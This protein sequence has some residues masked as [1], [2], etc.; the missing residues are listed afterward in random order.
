M[1]ERVYLTAVVDRRSVFVALTLASGCASPPVEPVNAVPLTPTP[2]Y[3]EWWA[4]ARACVDTTGDLNRITWFRADWFSDDVGGAV[5]YGLWV[6]PHTIYVRRYYEETRE[7]V[8][9]EMLHDLLGLAEGSAS[10]FHPCFT[11]LQL[12][13]PPPT[14]AP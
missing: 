4:E 3:A 12:L 10:H 2:A 11:T 9:H 1:G 8:E 14:P 5:T 7:V 13:W 6:R